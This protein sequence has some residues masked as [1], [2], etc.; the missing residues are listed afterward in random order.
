[1]AK[2]ADATGKLKRSQF[3]LLSGNPIGHVL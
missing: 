1:V 3:C 2:T